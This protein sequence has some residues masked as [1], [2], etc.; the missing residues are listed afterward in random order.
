MLDTLPFAEIWAVDFE[1]SAEPGEKPEPLC[2]VAWELRSGRKVRVWRDEFDIAPP[3]PTTP[4]ALFV[5][6]YASAE[7]SCHLVLAWLVP[8][9]VLDLFAEF[10]NLTNGVPTGNGAS[11]LGA[12]AFHGLDSIGTVEKEEMRDL[13]LRRGAWSDAERAAILDY[14]ESDVAA[15]ARL[16]YAMLPSIDLPRALLRGRYMTAAARMELNGVP[17]DTDTLRRLKRHWHDIQDR[18]IADI[19]ADYGV[20]DGPSFKSDRFAAWLA[21]AGIPW[22]R[23]AS[24]RLDLSDDAFREAALGHSAVAPLRELRCALSE[25]RS[26]DLAVGGDGRNRTILSAFRARTGRYQPSNTKFIFGP[27]VW[28]RGLIQPPPNHGIAYIDWEQQEFGVAAAL[29]GDARM[30]EAYHSGDPYLAF[31]KQAG[32]ASID[33][34]KATHKAVRNQFKACVLAVQYGMGADALAARIGQPPI[35]ARELLRLHRETYQ[36]FWRWSDAAVDHA[37]LTGSLHTVFGWRVQVPTISNHRS[38]RNFPMQANGAEMLRLACCLGTERGI[39][40]C[41]PIHDAVLI[42]APLDRLYADVARMHEAMRE[43]SRIVLAGFELRTDALAV[44]HPDRFMDERG[45]VMWRRVMTL[46]GRAET[47][48][49]STQQHLCLRIMEDAA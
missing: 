16:L 1:F 6:Y 25:M 15:L 12:L 9:R 20:F 28:V 47:E 4:D 22:P 17:I 7:I 8:E 37:M 18:L 31:A 34:T 39:E 19:D 5:A 40:I 10:R 26:S 42:C 36:V 48:V 41:A 33:A 14:C 43:A 32:A 24:G 27:S 49:L 11:L 21:R 2:L 30:S 44:L 45:T 3:Y 29:P 13:V 23:L 46:L 38:L 35:R